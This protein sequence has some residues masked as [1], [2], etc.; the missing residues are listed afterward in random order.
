MQGIKKLL[1]V[2]V[3]LPDGD[4]FELLRRARELA[5]PP[6]VFLLTARA[7]DAARALEMGALGYLT[8][9]ICFRDIAAAWTRSQKPVWVPSP[10]IRRP[11]IAHA[12]IVDPDEGACSEV[13]WE[14]HDISLTGAFLATN[15]PVESG[16]GALYTFSSRLSST[17]L[18]SRRS[19]SLD[20]S[21]GFS[22]SLPNSGSLKSPMT[23]VPNS[24]GDAESSK[25]RARSKSDKFDAAA[26]ATARVMIPPL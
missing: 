5:D 4:G 13:R 18:Y 11:P 17:A 23:S 16:A 15:G 26:F 1:L 10:R 12:L 6:E 21:S 24:S 3:V 2:D 14:I 25:L 7:C 22:E 19:S 8:K 20:P 9:P